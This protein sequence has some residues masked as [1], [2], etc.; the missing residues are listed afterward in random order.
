MFWILICDVTGLD[1]LAIAKRGESK[2]EGGF[3]IPRDKVVSVVASMDEDEDNGFSATD[4][5]GS[6]VFAGKRKPA[7]RRYREIAA[8]ETPRRGMVLVYAVST[9]WLYI[10]FV[11]NN[12]VSP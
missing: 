9:Y 6:D 8:N 12:V 7:G 10:V 3:K 4:D 1:V 11:A 5:T 2:V